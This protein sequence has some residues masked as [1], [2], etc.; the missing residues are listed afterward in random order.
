MELSLPF[1]LHMTVVNWY[2]CVC[3][4]DMYTSRTIPDNMHHLLNCPTTGDSCAL[5]QTD[6]IEVSNCIQF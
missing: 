1:P 4:C 2:L 6:G 5:E 3:R